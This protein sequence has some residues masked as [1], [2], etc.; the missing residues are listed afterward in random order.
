MKWLAILLALGFLMGCSY[1]AAESD[2][3]NQKALY[4]NYDHFKFSFEGYKKP[5]PED[6]QKSSEQGW[7]GIAVP[8]IP[9][10]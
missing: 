1:S 3:F 4:K 10:E 8:E 9:A 6:V 2:F 5:A 7:W